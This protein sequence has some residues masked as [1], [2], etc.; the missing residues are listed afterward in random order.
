MF[1][2]II[3]QVIGLLAVAAFLLSY[4]QKK[5]SGIILLN[6][7]SRFLYILQ[8]LMLGAFSGA[9]LDILAAGASVIAERK[10]KRK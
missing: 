8:Y 9:L 2:N 10:Q 6:V 4:Q 1:V 5:R 3:A 7:C